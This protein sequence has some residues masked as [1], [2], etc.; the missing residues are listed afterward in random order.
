MCVKLSHVHMMSAAATANC[1]CSCHCHQNNDTTNNTTTRTDSVCASP[2]LMRMTTRC[3]AALYAL[4]S[5]T[6]SL[7]ISASNVNSFW[8]VR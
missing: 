3:P 6:R 2:P 8:P 4:R 5:G 1:G 7:L